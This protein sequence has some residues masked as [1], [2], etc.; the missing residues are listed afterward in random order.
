MK[1]FFIYF[2]ALSWTV[3]ISSAEMLSNGSDVSLFV[4]E[5]IEQNDVSQCTLF[6]RQSLLSNNTLLN[7]L[8]TYTSISYHQSQIMIFAKTYCPYCKEAKSTFKSLLTE[9]GFEAEDLTYKVIE[10]DQLPGSDGPLIQNELYEITGQRTV[11]NVFIRKMHIGGN[12]DVQ[13]LLR[14][15]ELASMLHAYN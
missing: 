3:T 5:K 6:Y 11:P 14:E 13:A 2:A 8:D 1:S 15:N 10:L 9:L 12:D 4:A 7:V